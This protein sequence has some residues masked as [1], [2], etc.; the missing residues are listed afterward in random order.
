MSSMRSVLYTL[1]LANFMSLAMRPGAAA[2]KDDSKMNVLFV[3]IDDLRSEIGCWGYDYMITPNLDRL[4]TTGTRFTRT[5]CQQ[6]LCNPDNRWVH[7]PAP[8]PDPVNT[9]L[10]LNYKGELYIDPIKTL[11]ENTEVIFDAVFADLS[12]SASLLG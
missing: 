6:A 1:F 11:M 9:V 4:A 3:I 7:L 5:Y 10:V 8:C 2:Q 12:G